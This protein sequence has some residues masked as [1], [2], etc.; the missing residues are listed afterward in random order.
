MDQT[1]NNPF[2]YWLDAITDHYFD[3][4]GTSSRKE[5]W[6]FLLSAVICGLALGF[7]WL[8]LY[9]LTGGGKVADIVVGILCYLM[10]FFLFTLPYIALTVRRI[11]DIGWSP[12][13]ILLYLVIPV[14]LIAFFVFAC[15]PGRSGR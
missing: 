14:N 10:M 11:R 1:S 13:L 6:M 4:T 9:I 3:Y 2:K 12:W 5:V 7:V 15:T 8:N